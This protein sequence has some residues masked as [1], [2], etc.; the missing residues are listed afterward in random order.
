MNTGKD[1]KEKKGKE[2]IPIQ[3]LCL[4]CKLQ[5]DFL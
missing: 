5:V 2:H 4:F 1:R 3:L